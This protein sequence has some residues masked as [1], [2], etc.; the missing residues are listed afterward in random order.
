M[1]DARAAFIQS[2][3]LFNQGQ[4]GYL[5]A[6]SAE[7][8]NQT[9]STHE[10]PTPAEYIHNVPNQAPET[11]EEED[12]N[13][14]VRGKK[15]TNRRWRPDH[16]QEVLSTKPEAPLPQPTTLSGHQKVDRKVSSQTWKKE[17]SK[18]LRKI[19]EAELHITLVLSV[20]PEGAD[21]NRR[22]VFSLLRG[23][24]RICVPKFES[25]CDPHTNPYKDCPHAC[26]GT[27]RSNEP[28]WSLQ[29]GLARHV[30]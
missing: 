5:T 21:P 13:E 7:I 10:T 28:S 3:R 23:W 27:L 24:I 25:Q 22:D 14:V 6:E 9:V 16:G 4:P 15:N 18:S 26:I 19:H 17:E 20:D 29:C 1:H 11:P 8:S 12:V 2:A 30:R